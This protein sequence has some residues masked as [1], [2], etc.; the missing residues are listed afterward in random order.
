MDN[1]LG[2]GVLEVYMS[3]QEKINWRAIIET[4][5][6]ICPQWIISKLEQ[7]ESQGQ[8]CRPASRE[9]IEKIIWRYEGIEKGEAYGGQREWAEVLI[10]ALLGRVRKVSKA[11]IGTMNLDRAIE[12]SVR[13]DGTFDK[14][15]FK[16]CVEVANPAPK[17]LSV[18][19]IADIISEES[20]YKCTCEPD[21]DCGGC[22]ESLR[23]G[24][25]IQKAIY[26]GAE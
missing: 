19:E 8:I 2:M 16:S 5:D 15:W 9:E 21:S 24:K 3:K 10:D 26:G 22:R 17:V 23:I 4:G 1:G 20:N 12:E 13:E 18:E 14:E 7:A 11:E 25:I 6:G